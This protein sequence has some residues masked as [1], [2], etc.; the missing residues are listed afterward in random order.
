LEYVEVGRKIA[1]PGGHSVWGT[2][3]WPLIYWDCGFES[4]RQHVCRSLEID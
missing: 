1:Y 2:G 3:L 4:R